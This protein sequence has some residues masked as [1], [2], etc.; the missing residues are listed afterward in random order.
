MA[1]LLLAG[2]YFQ[3]GGDHEPV[4]KFDTLEEALKDPPQDGYGSN[5]E[6][7]NVLDLDTLK[8]THEYLNRSGW[9]AVDIPTPA[10]KL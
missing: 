5:A 6:W 9:A 7:A 8:I 3:Q 2:Q 10:A 4:C 1:Y